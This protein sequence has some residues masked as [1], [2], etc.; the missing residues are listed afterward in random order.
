MNKEE[1]L[2]RSRAEKNDEGWEY[3]ERK[4]HENA[5]VTI[6]GVYAILIVAATI[7]K[8]FTGK[9]FVDYRALLLA[10]LIGFVGKYFTKYTHSKEKSDLVIGIIAMG[11]ALCCLANMIIRGVVSI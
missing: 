8:F 1:V 4:A 2:K 3:I 11:G 5:F 6:I 7:Q 9:S 10:I